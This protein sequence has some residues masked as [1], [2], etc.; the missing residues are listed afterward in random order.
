MADTQYFPARA[1]KSLRNTITT[2]TGRVTEL[3]DAPAPETGGAA[4]SVARFK[5]A[6]QD[7]LGYN[8]TRYV[9]F[10]PEGDL[11][12]DP[13]G[14][15][16][17]D[18]ADAGDGA[19]LLVKAGVYMITAHVESVAGLE[20]SGVAQAKMQLSVGG[21]NA[22]PAPIAAQPATD[23]A[24]TTEITGNEMQGVILHT[25][26]VFIT[27][28]LD[29]HSLAPSLPLESFGVIQVGVTVYNPGAV[30][31]QAPDTTWDIGATTL[32]IVRLGDLP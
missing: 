2:L 23:I 20:I 16:V 31:F 3:E 17:G 29:L 32:T 9:A 11:L 30:D 18:G 12:F 22:G 13:D 14:L 21:Y 1:L 15:V 10:D 26:G 24:E 8:N 28:A 5:H 4:L 25:S 7:N 6:A 27:G 19:G